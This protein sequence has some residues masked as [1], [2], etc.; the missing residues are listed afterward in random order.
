MGCWTIIGS[1]VRGHRGSEAEYPVLRQPRTD[2]KVC[3][4]LGPTEDQ[5]NLFTFEPVQSYCIIFSSEQLFLEEIDIVD[6]CT[7]FA[8]FPWL[9]TEICRLFSLKKV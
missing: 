1:A 2:S 9:K 5:A 7:L 4:S 8:Y 3:R 6:L